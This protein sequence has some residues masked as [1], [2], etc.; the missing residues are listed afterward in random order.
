MHTREEKMVL[1]LSH[2]SVSGWNYLMRLQTW[3]TAQWKMLPF[4]VKES[5][6]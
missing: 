6:I 5:E 4:C 2:C 1:Q 3:R